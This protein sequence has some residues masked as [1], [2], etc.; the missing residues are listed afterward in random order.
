M[1]NHLQQIK[2]DGSNWGLNLCKEEVK[3]MD[4]PYNKILSM[5]PRR[6]HHCGIHYQSEQKM[7]TKSKHMVLFL[8]F[9]TS[10]FLTLFAS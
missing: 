3:C 7:R 8:V 1:L 9:D 2:V 5:V 4:S 6:T 10:R